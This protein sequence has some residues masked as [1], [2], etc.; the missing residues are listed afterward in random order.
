MGGSSLAVV[1]RFLSVWLLLLQ[2]MGCNTYGLQYLQHM[3]LDALQHM[4]SSQS[5]DWTYDP[6]F[7]K[8]V[9]SQPLD[10]QGSP[11]QFAF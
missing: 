8:Q 6:C 11:H 4:E 2:S 1:H 7:I 9:G 10:H 3:G 5:R